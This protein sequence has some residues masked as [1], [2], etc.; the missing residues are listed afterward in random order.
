MS[1]FDAEL[2]DEFF[3]PDGE[4][5]AGRLVEWQ[6]A[7][8]CNC[9]NAQSGHPAPN[10]E[11]C[12][13]V[14]HCYE[15]AESLWIGV[16]AYQASKK[17]TAVGPVPEGSV[18]LTIPVNSRNEHGKW[19]RSRLYDEI[20]EFDRFLLTDATERREISLVKDVRDN[21]LQPR[22]DKV[23]TLR[24]GRGAEPGLSF[25]EGL[26]FVIDGYRVRW[27]RGPIKGTKY[28][29][30]VQAHPVLYVYNARSMHRNHGVGLPKRIIAV[31]ADM[32]DRSRRIGHGAGE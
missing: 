17:W 3:D 31:A 10:C 7:S 15:P 26:D 20:G 11:F 24:V 4:W 13:G 32:L 1:A 25:V 16:T 30:D 2:F 9:M 5:K 23:N 21:H 29:L 6:R 19:V 12:W 28:I 8:L 22:I 18:T 27:L 14:G